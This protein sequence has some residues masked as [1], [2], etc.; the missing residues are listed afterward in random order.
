[1]PGAAT[2]K[3]AVP[4]RLRLGE[5][6]LV[7]IRIA[8]HEIELIS[9]RTGDVTTGRPGPRRDFVVA[10]AMTLRMRA[11]EGGL[12][13]EATAPETQWLEQRLGLLTDDSIIWR[14]LITPSE[15]GPNTL[16]IAASLRTVTSDGTATE[17]ALPPEIIKV[18]VKQRAGRVVARLT[19]W[20]IAA[21][22]GALLLHLAPAAIE[23]ITPL[24]AE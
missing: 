4:K 5:P 14:W 23:L 11:P 9:G 1:M 19:G 8:R 21:A 18:R 24:L 20:A 12:H 22:L 2:I 7:E 10:K 17:T 16:Q 6:E 15:T 13:V 3:A